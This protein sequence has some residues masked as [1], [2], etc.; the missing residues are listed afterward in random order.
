[1]RTQRLLELYELNPKLVQILWTKAVN[2]FLAII[3]K[4]K[5]KKAIQRAKDRL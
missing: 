4:G 3:I 5:I 2:I 1:M